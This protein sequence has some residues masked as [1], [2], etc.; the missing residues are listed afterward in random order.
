MATSSTHS[1]GPVLQKLPYDPIK[2]FAAITH[3]AN[4]PNVLVVSPKLE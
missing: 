4:V 1:I 3:V 2:D